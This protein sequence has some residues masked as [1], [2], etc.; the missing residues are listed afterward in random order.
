MELKRQNRGHGKKAQPTTPQRSILASENSRTPQQTA[1]NTSLNQHR[2]ISSPQKKSKKPSRKSFFN[3]KIILSLVIVVTVF[4][5]IGIVVQQ[6]NTPEVN[7]R[8]K[9]AR[10]PAFKTI[11]PEGKSINDLGGW[12]RISP[13]K[14]DPVFAYSDQIDGTPISVS[15]QPLPKSFQ[16][17]TNNNVAEVAKKFSATDKIEAGNTTIYIGI[18]A[19]GPQSV[20]FTK[21][22]LLILIKSQEKIED[23]SWARYVEAL[24]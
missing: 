21:N 13:P 9:T 22:D 20:I 16:G 6:Y 24:D 19:K 15:Q 11:L 12:K 8:N 1:Q 17:E 2:T 10:K 4:S 5:I 3:K 7:D 14:N 23:T 18:S